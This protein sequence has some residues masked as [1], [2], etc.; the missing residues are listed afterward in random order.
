M[1]ENADIVELISYFVGSFAIGYVSG[2][3]ILYFKKS[4][5]LIAR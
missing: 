1:I 3:L 2:F 5:G 4:V